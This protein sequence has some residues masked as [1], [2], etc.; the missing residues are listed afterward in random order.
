MAPG[1][2]YGVEEELPEGWEALTPVTHTFGTASPGD[3]F[4]HAFINYKPEFAIY[5]PSILR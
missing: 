3:R 2:S 1:H 4:T 5:L